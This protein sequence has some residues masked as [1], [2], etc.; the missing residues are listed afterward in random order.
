MSRM[1]R[2]TSCSGMPAAAATCTRTSGETEGLLEAPR[3]H[4]RELSSEA[5]RRTI[6]T[7]AGFRRLS[8]LPSIWGVILQVLEPLISLGGDRQDS[9]GVLQIGPAREYGKH[10]GDEHHPPP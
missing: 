9:R 7:S 4:L 8:L 6:S 2:W 5:R 3:V 10:H 1:A